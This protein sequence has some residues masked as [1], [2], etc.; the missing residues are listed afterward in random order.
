LPFNVQVLEPRRTICEK[1]M[2]LVRFSY[3]ENPIDAL[4]KKVR[5]TYDLYQLLQQQKYSDF[6]DS[7]EF[8]KMLLKVANDD[9]LSFKNNN[10]WLAYHPIEAL[11]FKDLDNVWNELKKVYNVEFREMVYGILPNENDVLAVL[12]RIKKRIETIIWLVEI[13]NTL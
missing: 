10:E 12:K 4:S 5:H 2:S 11:I 9:V 1:I 13:K 7:P 3:D 8:E 6:L